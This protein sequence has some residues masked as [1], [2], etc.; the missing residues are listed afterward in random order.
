MNINTLDLNLLLVFDAV[1]RT[2]ST[3]IAGEQIGVTQSAVSNALRRLR[4]A[5]DDEL[6]VRTECGM[7]P[8]PKA[9]AMAGPIQA[10]LQQIR[11]VVENRGSFDARAS[12]RHFRIA[13]SDIGQMWLV[14]QLMQELHELAPGA[15]LETVSLIRHGTV[16][17]M[18]S[19]EVDL[20]IGV[21][22]PLGAGYFRQRLR[23]LRFVCIARRDH[24]DIRGTLSV[25]QMLRASY[26]EY[27]PTGG[28]FSVFADRADGLFAERRMHR[29]VALKLAHLTG[30]DRAVAG[31]DLIAVVSEALVPGFNAN[32]GLQ[33]LELPFESPRLTVTQ[34]WHER[35]HKD[36]AHAWLRE[37]VARVVGREEMLG[38]IT[39][40]DCQNSQH[41]FDAL[42][43][44]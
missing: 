14:P 20:A 3:T 16:Q 31:S 18:S 38:P 26:I 10:A 8:T 2:H 15:T 13:V 35:I 5:F 37:V 6:F 36:P 23:T 42:A 1:Q 19:G 40:V 9:Q 25:E 11:Q 17:L 32:L 39:N 28:T 21:L 12:T 22:L 4:D 27:H 33:V 34:Q 44:D 30:I 41:S 7:M 29:R 24:P 43:V